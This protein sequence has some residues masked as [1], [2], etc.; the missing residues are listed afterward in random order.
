MEDELRILMA[1]LQMH[2]SVKSNLLKPSQPPIPQPLPQSHSQEG[3]LH[4]G[5]FKVVGRAVKAGPRLNHKPDL[6][7]ALLWV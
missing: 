1:K 4:A 7:V 2:N 3:G 6:V 5:G